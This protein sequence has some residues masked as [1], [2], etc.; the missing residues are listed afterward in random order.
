MTMRT[1]FLLLI[2][3]LL[4]N[5]AS[6]QT[7]QGTSL[8][9][10]AEAASVKTQEKQQKTYFIATNAQRR[11]V[12][13]MRRASAGTQVKPTPRIRSFLP[14]VDQEN[15]ELKHKQIADEVLR[16]MPTECVKTLRNFYVRY[17]NPAQRGLA[18]K[19]TLILSG[20]V[21][22][23]EFRA[24]LIHE[25]G[26]VFD[27][28]DAT[29][30]LGGTS[31]SGKSR[32]R[33]G[34]DLMFNDDPSVDFYSISWANEKT[35]RADARAEDFVTGYAAT[36]TFEDLAE[37]FAYFALQNGTFRERA[38]SNTALAE[39][40]Q[41]LSAQFPGIERNAVGQ[42]QW[43]GTVPWDATKLAYDWQPN[44]YIARK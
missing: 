4:C 13:R 29:A 40:Y 39:K 24:L 8:P 21:P 37:S 44:A 35:K 34:N 17:N 20:N 7:L 9:Q 2:G 16:L 27:L 38:K 30:C 18:G 15:I 28:S 32:F 23:A 22:D 1:K 33:D 19:N 11:L 43:N 10:Q 36:D 31:A 25:L 12:A 6:P 5:V 26:H 41:W 42:S 3:L 14:I